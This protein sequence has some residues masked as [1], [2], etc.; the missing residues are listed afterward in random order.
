MTKSERKVLC[1]TLLFSL[2]GISPLWA[3]ETVTFHSGDRVLHGVV[4]KPEGPGPFPAVLYNHG[5]APGMLNSTAF[6]LLGPM[7]VAHGWAFFAPYR[8]GQGLSAEAGPY[9]G[10]EIEA[11]RARGGQ[12]AAAETMIRLLS[13]EHLQDQLAALAWIKTHPLCE[14]I[15]WL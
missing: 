2:I 1:G 9:I 7:F 8:R 4:Y 10:D 3:S 11:A 5:S 13:T 15:E 12:A 14:Q 6:E